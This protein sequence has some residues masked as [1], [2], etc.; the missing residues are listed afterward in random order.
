MASKHPGVLSS[1]E[2]SAAQAVLPKD[3][4]VLQ[5]HPPRAS[6][7]LEENI[8]NREENSKTFEELLALTS[9]ETKNQPEL[10]P[11]LSAIGFEN[12]D[13]TLRCSTRGSEGWGRVNH[14]H[15]SQSPAQEHKG[16]K[17]T[18]FRSDRLQG[19]GYKETTCE[20]RPREMQ[21]ER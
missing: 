7:S 9:G 10:S 13:C 5:N 12:I 21:L 14:P 17:C 16:K 19:V 2:K 11:S 6:S 3:A 4:L 1:G 15:P 20:A 18:W 8:R